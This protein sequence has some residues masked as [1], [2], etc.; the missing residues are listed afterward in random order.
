K[1][2]LPGQLGVQFQNPSEFGDNLVVSNVAPDTAAAKAGIKTG[3]KITEIDGKKV[4]TPAQAK[5]V[6]GPKYEG[7]TVTVKYERAGQEMTPTFDRVGK[8]KVYA[9]PYLGVLPMR[10]APKL[11]VEL[12]FVSPNS[13][14]DK[15]GLKA[16][17]R[18]VK[19]GTDKLEDFQGKI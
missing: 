14:A 19:Y 8:M 15:A 12:R 11:G 4:A 18:I 10:D 2:L 17:E 6:L 13:P 3:D 5:H 7:A 9:T 1:D 16:G